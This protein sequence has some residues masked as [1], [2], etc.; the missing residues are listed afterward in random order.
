[1]IK[2]ILA[3]ILTYPLTLQAQDCMDKPLSITA[4]DFGQR[5][6]MVPSNGILKIY[7]GSTEGQVLD[8]FKDHGEPFGG[9]RHKLEEEVWVDNRSRFW[10][11]V[12]P[13]TPEPNK[14]YLI[15]NLDQETRLHIQGKI[16]LPLYITIKV[17]NKSYSSK[18]IFSQD[19]SI[20]CRP[21]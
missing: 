7:T 15:L 19:I 5:E 10:R 9:L 20:N 4:K 17:L 13:K 2:L 1:M 14:E 18:V 16:N 3:L 11:W 6:L 8:V 12:N 21:N